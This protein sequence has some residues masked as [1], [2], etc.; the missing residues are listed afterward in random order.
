LPIRGDEIG[1]IRQ[2][3]Y[4]IDNEVWEIPRGFGE[5]EDPKV[6]AI[7]ELREETGIENAEMVEL[8]SIHPNSGLLVSN[9]H[10]FAARCSKNTQ[11]GVGDGLEADEFRWLLLQ[12]ALAEVADGRL[13][14]G[15]TLCAI[16]L[17]QTKG[18]I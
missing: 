18:L 5:S 11:A 3:R 15:Y 4:P 13:T 16:L 10:V 7:R 14:D 1:L 12:D 8:G 6:D 9:V 17:A 2:Y